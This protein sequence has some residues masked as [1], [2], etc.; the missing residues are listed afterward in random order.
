MS[1][2]CGH[3]VLPEDDVCDA[4]FYAAHDGPIPDELIDAAIRL[5]S[6]NDRY[7]VKDNRTKENAQMLD[8]QMDPDGSCP[9]GGERLF[10]DYV[11]DEQVDAAAAEVDA[12]NR[13]FRERYPNRRMNKLELVTREQAESWAGRALSG[14]ELERL[15]DAIPN[16]S[17]P[18]AVGT[19]V[20]SWEA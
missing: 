18:D 12:M 3:P 19:I 10:A 8:G 13:R 6:V 5:L 9:T 2:E 16:S 14:D 15:S 11:T 4:C 1:S 20:S 17:I 7:S